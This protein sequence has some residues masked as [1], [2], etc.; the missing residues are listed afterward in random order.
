MASHATDPRWSKVLSLTGHELRNPL[1][2]VV[3]YIRMVLSER[4]GPLAP[5]QRKALEESMNSCGRLREIVEQLGA[6]RDLEE[7]LTKLQNVRIQSGTLLEEAIEAVPEMTDRTV[8]IQLDRGPEEVA[9]SGDP[10]RLP[11]A[12]ASVIFAIRREVV[13]SDRVVVRQRL[14]N[15]GSSRSLWIAIGPPE[16]VDQLASAEAEALT[17]F[18]EW[19]GGLGLSLPIARR[20][21]NLHGGTVWSPVEDPRAGAALAL[22]A[23]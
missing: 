7:G 9:V 11:T 13:T 22:P 15:D 17:T 10:A 8:A 6:L 4:S 19:R 23:M 1:G 18:D 2:V 12:L 21:I 20:V 3:G 16:R 5:F 14:T